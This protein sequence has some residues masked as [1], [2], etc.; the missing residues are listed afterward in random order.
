M[1]NR[2]RGTDRHRGEK[3]V[4]PQP[5]RI[6]KF[7]PNHLPTTA[8][9]LSVQIISSLFSALLAFAATSAFGQ[10]GTLTDSPALAASGENGTGPQ[11]QTVSTPQTQ[12]AVPESKTLVKVGD[13][14]PDFT[15]KMF[16]G[17]TVDI[18]S[19]KG[20]VVLINFWATWCPPCRAELKQVQKQIIDRFAGRDFVFLP[21]SRGETREAV[22][23][24]REMQRWDSIR[25]A[26]ST[27]FSPPQRF[28]ATSSSPRTAPSS[29]ARPD[30]V[31]NN[32][33]N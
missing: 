3:C 24:F 21:I 27:R 5:V 28:H 16:D 13:P 10:T 30:I 18:A 11:A 33:P 23:K 19:L 6:D 22:E 8:M 12:A 17:S 2:R 4:K 9:K 14:V 32:S 26:K 20:K 1:Q 31:R 15:V 29:P 7:T 25:S